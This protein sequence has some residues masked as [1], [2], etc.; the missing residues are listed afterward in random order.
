MV[1]GTPI[2]WFINEVIAV[3]LFC[4]VTVHILKRERPRPPFAGTLFLHAYR[5][6]F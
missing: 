3:A 2:S 6:H 4:I 5:G 1:F